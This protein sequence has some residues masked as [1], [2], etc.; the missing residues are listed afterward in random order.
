MKMF[1]ITREIGIDMGH[2]VTH[3]GS[4]CRNLHGHRY[5]VQV[6]AR[7][8]VLH[9]EGEQQGMTLDF[10]FL[11]EEMMDIIDSVHDHGTTLWVHDPLV[12][13]F[14][15]EDVWTIDA[16]K[17]HVIRWGFCSTSSK[18]GKVCF[19]PFV[20][21]AEEL[22]RFWYDRLAERVEVRSNKLAEIDEVKV[23]ET[24]NCFAVYRGD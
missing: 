4:K 14:L 16:L 8:Y 20:P 19:V 3:H 24:P 15:E 18:V 13:M 21:T 1:T 17:A 23:Y 6:T 9:K 10:S 12:P 22:A 11:K 2:R 7:S 5:T